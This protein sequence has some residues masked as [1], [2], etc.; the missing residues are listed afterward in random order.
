MNPI[1]SH[2]L[3]LFVTVNQRFDGNCR[4]LAHR[5]LAALLAPLF[6]LA[7]T[8]TG[9]AQV[10]KVSATLEG[11]LLDSTGAVIPGAEIKL[12]N[13]DTNQMRTV[14]TDEQGFYR[15]SELPVG[16]YEVRVEQDGFALYHHTGV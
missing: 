5:R 15:A 3:V 6:A 12:R 7:L 13:I 4:S 2:C 1:I 14:K 16:A 8:A 9:V 10:S 11:T